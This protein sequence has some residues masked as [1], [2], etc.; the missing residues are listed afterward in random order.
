MS[1]FLKDR[2]TQSL[3]SYALFN[4]SFLHT[5]FYYTKDPAKLADSY[6]VIATDVS[7]T[8]AYRQHLTFY[9]IV[10]LKVFYRSLLT[11]YITFLV[12]LCIK[13]VVID[14]TH[15]ALVNKQESKVSRQKGYQ[16]KDG[17]VDEV[18]IADVH[19]LMTRALWKD[20]GL[21][22]LLQLL[23]AQAIT[24]VI[25][26]TFVSDPGSMKLASHRLVNVRVFLGTMMIVQLVLLV[27]MNLG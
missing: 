27:A 2:N 14:M 5:T 20:D 3:I 15:A 4:M 1:T 7:V 12:I 11:V 25:V 22:R 21:F 13:L 18:S 8:T 26:A 10:V 9:L 24:A 23:L 19:D 16:T 6:P 17:N